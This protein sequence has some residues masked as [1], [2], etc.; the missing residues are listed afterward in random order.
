MDVF[1]D[2]VKAF[3]ANNAERV[4]STNFWPTG[5]EEK[6]SF[7]FVGEEAPHYSV[8][9]GQEEKTEGHLTELKSETFCHLHSFVYQ[10]P[11]A[12]MVALLGSV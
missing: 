11:D 9:N 3:R 6:Q 8:P 1:D 7:G 12:S 10:A 5:Q 4:G 2:F